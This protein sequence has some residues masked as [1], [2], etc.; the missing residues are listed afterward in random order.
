[1]GK[2]FRLLFN[3]YPG[4]GRKASLFII[5]ALLWSVGSYGTLTLSEG[6]FL[7]YVGAQS[8]PSTY[9]AIAV[10]MCLLSPILIFSLHRLPIRSLLFSLIT[11]WIGTNLTFYFTLSLGGVNPTY[12]TLFKIIGWIVPISTYIVFWAFVD[13]YY[14]LQDGKRFFCLFNAIT[15]LGDSLGGGIISFFIEWLNTGGLL[16]LFTSAMA[17]SLPFILLITKRVEPVLEDFAES[18]DTTSTP[19]FKTILATVLKSKFTLYLLFFYFFMQLLA[20][21][22]EFNCMQSFQKIYTTKGDHALTEFLGTCGMYISLGNMIFA[23]FLYSRLVKKMGVNNLIL[24][25][26][27]F[28]MAIFSVWVWKDAL[29]IAIFGLIAREGMI[30]T[31]DDNNLNLLISGVPSKVKNQ[32]RIFVESFIE[33]VGMFCSALL[34]LFFNQASRSLGLIMAILASVVVLFLRAQYPKAIFRN[35]VV[36]AIRFEKKAVEWISQLTSKEKKKTEFLL[37]SSLKKTQESD[38]LIA[39]EY[40]LKIGT[41]KML[42]RLLDHVGKLTLPGKLKAIDLLSDSLW[43]KEPI[44]LERLERWRQLLPH[45]AIKSAIHFY[46]AKH[47]LLRPEKIM[48]DL[49]HEHLGLRAAAILTLKTTPF[50]PQLPSFYSLASEK[51]RTLLDSKLEQEI[52]VGLKI[53]GL[54]KNPQNIGDLFPYLKHPSLTINRAAARALSEA[55]HP[56][57]TEYVHQIIARLAYMRD[58][59][60][61]SHCLKALGKFLDAESVKDLILASVH[62]RSNERKLVEQ[63]V[64]EIGSSCVPLLLTLTK[65][66]KIHDRCR[67]LAGK[68]LGKMDLKALQKDL[69]A[70]VSLEI[71]R[72]YFYFYHAQTIQKQ[73][74]EQ[75]LSLLE[76]ALMTTY[77]SIIDFIIQLLGV[78]GKVE[79]SEILSHTLKSKN[80][81]IRAQAVESLEKSCE[82][83]IFTLLEPLIDE[84]LLDEKLRNYLKEGKLP[85]NLTQLLDV[86]NQSPSVADQIISI[87]L[88]ARFKTPDWQSALREKLESQ[89]EIFHH[90]AHELLNPAKEAYEP[91]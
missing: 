63:I 88:K 29:P 72:A 21:V 20:I 7:E 35:L 44:I 12:W 23:M 26:P 89:N 80:R 37:F 36:S 43:A 8:L 24:I 49:H 58:P 60:V 79:D 40:L 17:L 62:F 6:M 91:N 65:E 83:K 1:M 53:L 25:A 4:E 47:G 85:L 82:T 3:L 30:Y 14:D 50:S 18:I 61:R 32:V 86:L 33:P 54:E 9:I 69:F 48:H 15:F 73:V 90:F 84:R 75:D 5:L 10:A 31:L 27:S 68:I 57:H 87:S 51:L 52:L 19:K 70:I 78:A 74:P 11:L 76:N 38:Q 67:L 42:P 28:F 13:Q 45:L 34:L 39:F 59:E 56:G 22:T 16:L 46:F 81:K 66:T 41:E 77:Q 2:T 64:L 55:A 71:E